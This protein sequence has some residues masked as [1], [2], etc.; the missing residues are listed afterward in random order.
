MAYH[1][2]ISGQQ[3]GPHT[4]FELIGLIRD[5]TLKGD[6]LV[7]QQGLKDWSPI[8]ELREF[9]GYWPITEEV[10]AKA[11]SARLVARSELDRPQPWLRFWARI[12][13]YLWFTITVWMIL[14]LLLPQNALDWMVRLYFKGAPLDPIILFLFVPIEAWM[15]SRRGTT[16][17]KSL[18]RVQVCQL[19]GTLPTYKQ[20]LQRSL[21]VY[22]KGFAMGLSLLSLFTMSFSR[23]R[24]MQ[25]KTTS[26]DEVT[27]LRV[28]HGEPEVWRFVLL[29][30]A[31]L[32][33]LMGAGILFSLSPPV[34][35]MMKAMENLPK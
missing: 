32:I 21:L 23:A 25:H 10:I 33:M 14:G 9:E 13:D 11:E 19:D 17:G 34:M 29:F 27:G 35:E 26:W 7:W 30:C 4:Q 31:A 16:L 2:S 3:T 5:G 28:E 20:A 22:V 18:L 6:E 15:L 24:L 12:V 1:L 8:K